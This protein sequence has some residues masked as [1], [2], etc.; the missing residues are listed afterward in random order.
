LS[1]TA[2]TVVV[3]DR[4]SN[5]RLLTVAHVGHSR[6]V[7]GCH[8]GEWAAIQLTED[9]TPS[10]EEKKRIEERG[11]VVRIQDGTPRVFAPQ[12]LAPGLAMSR[13]LGDLVVKDHGVIAEPEVVRWERP[14]QGWLLAASD[15]L[16]EF[17]TTKQVTKLVLEGLR[18]GDAC[19]N[20]VQR[21]V[22][23]AQAKWAFYEGIYCDDITV[24]LVAIGKNMAAPHGGSLPQ[25]GG[26][27]CAAGILRMCAIEKPGC[28]LQ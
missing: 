16:W 15:G 21:L 13:S 17:M 3:E 1:G 27:S 25:R 20:V 2:A 6:A 24:A 19:E 8:N 23:E 12:E 18:R 10:D 4:R 9:H 26:N 5:R 14:S 7:I 28:V 11:G 22:S